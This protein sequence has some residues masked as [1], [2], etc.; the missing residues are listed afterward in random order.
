MVP[1]CHLEEI[2]V[3]GAVERTIGSERIA[4]FRLASGA[5][6][7]TVAACPHKGGPL[8]FGLVAGEV[9]YCPL[10][11][12]KISLADGLV[13]DGDHGSVPLYPVKVVDEKVYVIL[14][15]GPSLETCGYEEGCPMK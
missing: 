1:V 8:C 5:V 7:A 11:E 14:S 13:E 12:W 3:L 9:V 4:L 6:R 10:H 2:P 15:K